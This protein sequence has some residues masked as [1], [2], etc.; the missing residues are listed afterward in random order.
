MYNISMKRI[1]HTILMLLV[2]SVTFAQSYPR[3]CTEEDIPSSERQ[4]YFDEAKKH[5]NYYYVQ[6]PAAIGDLDNR[7]VLIDA[8]MASGLSSLKPGFLLDGI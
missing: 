2:A 8:I 5:V 7:E 3:K 1:L 6:I 4:R